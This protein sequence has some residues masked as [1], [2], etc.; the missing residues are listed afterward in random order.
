[1]AGKLVPSSW[2]ICKSS[3]KNVGQRQVVLIIYLYGLRGEGWVGGGEGERAGR[4]CSIKVDTPGRYSTGSS[5]P[6]TQFTRNSNYGVH[7]R[8]LASS[9]SVTSFST[10]GAP[11]IFLRPG[12]ST[13]A[14][15]GMRRSR[16]AYAVES[17]QNLLPG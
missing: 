10:L 3:R 6:R 14:Y 12:A 16:C 7:R 15:Q 13:V 1:M 17:E 2:L 5:K 11:F 8:R 4:K 9:S